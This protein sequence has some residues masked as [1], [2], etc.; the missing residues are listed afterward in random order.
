MYVV[1]NPGVAEYYD[2]FM[3]RLNNITDTPVWTVSH[4]GH[5]KP[6]AG[7]NQQLY[8]KWQ[9]VGNVKVKLKT[10]EGAIHIFKTKA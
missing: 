4:A 6:P 7:G 1:G 5:V 2:E 9:C 10:F 8:G 3:K